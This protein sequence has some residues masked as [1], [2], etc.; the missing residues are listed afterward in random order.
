MPAP[1]TGVELDVRETNDRER[2]NAVLRDEDV[3]RNSSDDY[4]PAP[5][6]V[7]CGALLLNAQW[8][9][10]GIFA[11]HECAGVFFVVRHSVILYEVHTAI[12]PAY[13]GALASRAALRLLDRLFDATPCRK[14]TTLVPATNRPAARF[15][16]QAGLRYQGTLTA[17][18]LKDGVL[19]DQEILGITRDEHLARRA[20][21]SA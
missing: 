9:A 5:A 14:L 2:L 6:Q 12:L 10:F 19:H 21:A 3:F 20:A 18:F 1:I 11:G 15:A 16:R 4:A 8:T 7:D 17:S 13:R